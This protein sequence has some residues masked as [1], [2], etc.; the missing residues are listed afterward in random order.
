MRPRLQRLLADYGDYHRHPRNRI[1]HEIGIPLIVF[2]VVAMLDW[3]A[4]FGV[5]Q[6][7]VTSAHLVL[8][9]LGLWYLSLD[10]RLGMLLVIFSAACLAL[11]TVTPVW[12]VGVIAV[13]GWVIQFVG[14]S[15]WEKR[16]PAFADDVVGLL[17]G[18]LFVAAL[19]CGR[20]VPETAGTGGSSGG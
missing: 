10:L 7:T 9:P 18:P 13:V 2:H 12:A 6:V 19:L 20:P 1:A 5:G 14:H 15:V 8:L 17:V 4:L 16:R 11:G 3:V